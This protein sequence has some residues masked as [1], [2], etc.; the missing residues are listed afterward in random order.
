MVTDKEPDRQG[1]CRDL[2]ER[3]SEYLDGD[4]EEGCCRELERHLADCADCVS[5][6]DDLSR[7]LSLCRQA[8]SFQDGELSLS[9]DFSRRL[10]AI[11]L[12]QK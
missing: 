10:R 7:M 2:L 6:V 5:T 4:L 8:S 12:S 11:V 3:F 1:H 9:D